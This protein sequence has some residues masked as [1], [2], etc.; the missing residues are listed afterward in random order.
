MD[1]Y[2]YYCVPNGSYMN[3]ETGAFKSYLT[4]FLLSILLTLAAYFIVVEHVFSSRILIYTIIGLGIIQ[5]FIQ[6]LFFLH[7]GQE[8]KPYWNFQLFL[9]MITILL[10]LI[11]G[12][13]WIMENL[14]Y[15]VK[16]NI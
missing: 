8:P 1:F 15:N 2:L 3:Q 12:S 6:L 16:P 4:G 9:F 7:L 13:L 10:I 5:M 11:I 14:R